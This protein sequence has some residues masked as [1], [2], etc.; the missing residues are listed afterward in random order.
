MDH[1]THVHLANLVKLSE[2]PRTGGVADDTS[3]SSCRDIRL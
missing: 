3:I 1:I 2:V